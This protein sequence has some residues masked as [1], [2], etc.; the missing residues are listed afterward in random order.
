MKINLS[1]G[2]D[3]SE[4]KKDIDNIINQLK[5]VKETKDQLNTPLIDDK[6]LVNVNK[7][8]SEVTDSAEK[9]V[10]EIV[11]TNEEL[12]N[13]DK[14][15]SKGLSNVGSSLKD[16]EKQ[17]KRVSAMFREVRNEIREMEL[18][19]ENATNPKRYQELVKEAQKYKIAM[20]NVGTALSG[21]SVALERTVFRMQ[22]ITSL[23][24]VVTG[25][26]ALFGIENEKVAKTLTRLN[27]LMTIMN[28]LQGI[29]TA[30][31]RQDSIVRTAWN[32]ITTASIRATNGLRT[33]LVKTGFGAIAVGLG[34][35]VSKLIDFNSNVKEGTKLSE[36]ASNQATQDI[37][38]LE[39]LRVKIE[40][41]SA[42]QQDRNK[43]LQELRD[44]YPNILSN[45]SDEE[46]L[47]GNVAGAY[48]RIRQSIID[49]S[50][51]QAF[52]AKAEE[53]VGQYVEDYMDVYE[54]MD[55]LSKRTFNDMQHYLSLSK[56]QR[57]TQIETLGTQIQQL[58]SQG[59]SAE[60]LVIQ[61]NLLKTINKQE[62]VRST[63]MNE[64]NQLLDESERIA[65]ALNVN[66]DNVS[67]STSSAKDKMKS[68]VEELLKLEKSVLFDAM[69]EGLEK[70]L[71]KVNN[72]FTEQISNLTNIEKGMRASGEMTE[73][74]QNRIDNL[75]SI[76]VETFSTDTADL[77]SNFT[78]TIQDTIAEV[79][80]A[81]AGEDAIMQAQEKYAKMRADVEEQL[82]LLV[83]N[84][85]HLNEEEL[86]L[87]EKLK[88]RIVAINITER[89]E[90][91]E[92]HKE[93]MRKM[94]QDAYDLSNS[95]LSTVQRIFGDSADI[96]DA[97]V[98]LSREL[99]QQLGVTT[100]EIEAYLQSGGAVSPSEF[101][102]FGGELL[103]TAFSDLATNMKRSIDS[104]A[105]IFERSGSSI[106]ALIALGISGELNNKLKNTV[107]NAGK[108]IENLMRDMVNSIFD[109]QKMALEA[110]MSA[111]DRNIDYIQRMI[112]EEK[113]MLQDRDMMYDEDMASSFERDETR[114]KELEEQMEL[115]KEMKQQ[116][117]DELLAIEIKQ[118]KAEFAM[119]SAQQVMNSVTALSAILKGSAE[120]MASTASI[121]FVGV[122]LG[123]AQ[124][125]ALVAGYL[126]MKSKIEA[127]KQDVP[128]FGSGGALDLAS[129]G[130]SHNQG[131][132]GLH[133][134]DGTKVAEYERGEVLY[135]INKRERKYAMPL[136]NMLNAGDLEGMQLM[137]SS[138]NGS[139]GNDVHVKNKIE[140]KTD[141][142]VSKSLDTLN[143]N[144]NKKK[145]YVYANGRTFI[146][147]GN[148]T[149]RII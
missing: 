12:S 29:Q 118:T 67:K 14:I 23:A 143:S 97:Q 64:V 93:G 132:L 90:I 15:G 17:T 113:E 6:N 72:E 131:G 106:G 104:Q 63:V 52:R 48:D 134:K 40:N 68:Y 36:Y 119:Q 33:A 60:E 77:I 129:I 95:Q 28:G 85:E 44:L 87:E 56:E 116:L 78:Q 81:L 133:T 38:K 147:A 58:Q 76:L 55:R 5:E 75:K 18:S 37:S 43:A 31:V 54:D 25:G 11:R 128:K 107:A 123:I 86:K 69:S 59:A 136:L 122:A 24:S 62:S 20:D 111:I 21:Q 74:F 79:D 3:N 19:G 140:I 110:Q 144:L 94:Y 137:L 89:E 82:A 117:S 114:L 101:F 30:M 100:D 130:H 138:I 46:I 71:Q 41:V 96:R 7:E 92:L 149:I 42:S 135:A 2:G 39:Q 35:L 115:E 126:A 57:D 102:G 88:D 103:D 51:A 112:D 121:P 108:A 1:F 73:D 16:T 53:R 142:K 80:S 49:L 47:A 50:I 70:E 141:K 98:R 146:K 105:S 91:E 109:A 99:I 124:A 13:T 45:L 9:L 66:M 32:A 61:Q 139:L 10:G 148:K 65:G 145:E 83:E 120:A 27:A 26:M 127:M 22:E 34:Y 84:K 125:G 8:L 4:L